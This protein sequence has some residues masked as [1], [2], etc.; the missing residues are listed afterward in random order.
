MPS[1]S[2]VPLKALDAEFLTF[3][4]EEVHLQAAPHPE[5]KTLKWMVR[6]VGALLPAAVHPIRRRQ[7]LEFPFP[8]FQKKGL[9]LPATGLTLHV[10]RRLLLDLR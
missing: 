4:D 2:I 3:R 8:G 9:E 7:P 1:P 6:N 10:A 5:A